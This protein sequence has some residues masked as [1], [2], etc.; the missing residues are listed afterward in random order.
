[1]MFKRKKR[2]TIVL[3]NFRFSYY[4]HTYGTLDMALQGR[5]GIL[6]TVLVKLRRGVHG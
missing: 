5:S 2:P 3:E 4:T 6:E 1:M